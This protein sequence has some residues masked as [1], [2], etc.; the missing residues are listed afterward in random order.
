MRPDTISPAPAAATRDPFHTAPSPTP[1]PDVAMAIPA[2]MITIPAKMNRKAKGFNG[3][4]S[5]RLARS[6][7][8]SRDD[9]GG[10]G[11]LLKL[12]LIFEE[13]VLDAVHQRQPARLDHVFADA[14]GAPDVLRIAAFDDHAHAG[15][16]P[17]AGVDDANLVIDKLHL[18]Q[19]RIGRQECLPQRRVER[20]D[21]TVSLAHD[22]LDLA[23][24]LQF[25]GRF[26][27]WQ[28]AVGRFHVH[29]IADSLEFR[30]VRASDFLYQQIE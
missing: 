8:S 25:D 22:M 3:L 14:D 2:T 7:L 30:L 19:P 24:H 23:F 9:R 20:V 10:A 27:L 4:P 6:S 16:G 1:A 5:P 15:G 26:S 12:P 17:F 18:L 29:A 21:G 11:R 28:A 13:F